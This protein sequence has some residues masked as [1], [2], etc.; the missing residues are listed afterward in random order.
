MLSKY[1]TGTVCP[2]ENFFTEAFAWV[3]KNN[4]KLCTKLMKE[5]FKVS[6]F[7]GKNLEVKTQVRYFDEKSDKENKISYIDLQIQDDHNLIFLENKISANLN[8]YSNNGKKNEDTYSK[9]TINQYEKYKS[10]QDKLETESELNKDVFV[11]GLKDPKDEVPYVA[12][13]HIYA[14][15]EQWSANEN[16]GNETINSFLDFMEVKSMSTFKGLSEEF[17]S[18][19]LNSESSVYD[20]RT[21]KK[22]F[23]DY[24]SS[25]DEELN[26]DKSE[27]WST[28]LYS[29]SSNGEVSAHFTYP[30]TNNFNINIDG[31]TDGLS[32]HL[33]FP[34]WNTGKDETSDP[35]SRDLVKNDQIIRAFKGNKNLFL[36]K[37][38]EVV[39]SLNT[40]ISLDL[41]GKQYFVSASSES[42]KAHPQ[43]NVSTKIFS[44]N[45]G[46]ENILNK[47]SSNWLLKDNMKIFDTPNTPT[48]FFKPDKQLLNCLLEQVYEDM[49]NAKSGETN[50]NKFFIIFRKHLPAKYIANEKENITKVSSEIIQDLSQIFEIM[51]EL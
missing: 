9:E 6:T 3:L 31:R 44:L 30:N 51:Q 47:D 27:G 24:V 16:N 45:C 12:W 48:A 17:F 19:L 32:I 25:I 36:S 38:N 50:L 1:P 18:G 37:L 28:K 5:V 43:N 22:T 13:S 41:Y 33:Y 42:Q 14:F 20:D 39:E 2:E 11:V 7:S 29:R 15:L 26:K 8:Q 4:P 49:N 46:S 35:T 34:L 40:T 10:I 21:I 23:A